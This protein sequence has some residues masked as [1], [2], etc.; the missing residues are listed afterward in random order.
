MWEIATTKIVHIFS[1]TFR[2]KVKVC[3]PHSASP[4]A[5]VGLKALL[6]AVPEE[7]RGSSVA[8]GWG[9]QSERDAAADSGED[10]VNAS[11]PATKANGAGAGAG[12]STN[13]DDEDLRRLLANSPEMV[14]MP[15][16]YSVLVLLKS[17]AHYTYVSW[18]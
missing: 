4:S 9:H 2:N 11:A 13:E 3:A 7:L 10:T 17:I 16:V 5:L 15:V 12:T 8:R 6:V 1:S 14:S 18:K